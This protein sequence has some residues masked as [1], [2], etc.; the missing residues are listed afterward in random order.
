MRVITCLTQKKNQ[1]L[2]TKKRSMPRSIGIGDI[3]MTKMMTKDMRKTS[4]LDGAKED[5]KEEGAIAA[6]ENKFHTL[7]VKILA[8]Q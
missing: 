8:Q 6:S 4:T 1:V 2:T 3:A 7:K 5:G